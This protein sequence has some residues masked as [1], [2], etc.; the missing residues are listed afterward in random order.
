M[1][2]FI[3]LGNMK[4]NYNIFIVSRIEEMFL[5]NIEENNVVY[6]KYNL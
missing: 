1:I 2:K 4:M 6:L 3:P 5:C